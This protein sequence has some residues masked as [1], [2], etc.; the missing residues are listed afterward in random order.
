VIEHATEGLK[1]TPKGRFKGRSCATQLYALRGQ[2]LYHKQRFQEAEADLTR[3]V[4]GGDAASKKCL[5]AVRDALL[6][7]SKDEARRLQTSA[8]TLESTIALESLRE[9]L[10]HTE[11]D[12]EVEAGLQSECG[13][14]YRDQSMHKE[15]LESFRLVVTALRRCEDP[16]MEEVVYALC[17]VGR[18]CLATG[19]TAGARRC[20]EDA[21]SIIHQGRGH[22]ENSSLNLAEARVEWIWG[23]FHT[24]AGDAGQALSHYDRG[25]ALAAAAG[26]DR[27]ELRCLV[28]LAESLTAQG[29]PGPASDILA[30]VAGRIPGETTK[31][32]APKAPRTREP[33]LVSRFQ[34]LLRLGEA[35]A[36]G[37]KHGESTAAYDEALTCSDC[38]SEARAAITLALAEAS[39]QQQVASRGE[40]SIE[41]EERETAR[42]AAV[43]QETAHTQG[44]RVEEAQASMLAAQ[45]AKQSGDKDTARV[46]FA[47]AA[48]IYADLGDSPR[49][50]GEAVAM[51]A[52]CAR[53]PREAIEMLEAALRPLRKVS[54]KQAR[55]HE[56]EVLRSI[57]VMR[58]E[59]LR[60]GKGSQDAFQAAVHLFSQGGA[61]VKAAQTL[62]LLG[63]VAMQIGDL[64][65]ASAHLEEA[66]GIFEAEG[67]G[68][69]ASKTRQVLGDMRKLAEGAPDA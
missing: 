23:A 58:G 16:P 9:A 14:A 37:G 1:V 19:D 57:A 15:A 13:L 4:E 67:E 53:D 69:E 42:R 47:R 8:T 38:T 49:E 52:K 24:A 43:A 34:V 35:C 27:E 11:G 61:P 17:D 46:N 12:L 6:V 29:R 25:R 22:A 54:G 60:D 2:A 5:R 68:G 31:K 48:A 18:E 7:P 32:P 63:G 36:K 10:K 33:Q 3:A 26:E 50:E 66:I 28:G 30:G 56:G 55:L 44:A 41:E 20:L 45:H 65:K 51:M 40:G 64:S 62:R 59:H 39:Q 21:S